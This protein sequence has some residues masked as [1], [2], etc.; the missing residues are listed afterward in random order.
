MEKQAK[1]MTARGL[2]PQLIKLISDHQSALEETKLNYQR[3][4]TEIVGEMEEKHQNS[5]VKK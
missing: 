2:E 1:E 4:I 3:K 5:M